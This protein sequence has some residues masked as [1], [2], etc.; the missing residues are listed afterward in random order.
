VTT[1]AEAGRANQEIPD[2]EQLTYATA[3]G[4]VLVT[5]DRDFVAL[6]GTG[7]PHAGIIYMQRELAIGDAI[8]YLEIMAHVTPMEEM[9]DRLVYCA[10]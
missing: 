5:R 3:I 10:W 1:T 6:A 2:T 4:C 7:Q 9:R 8:D